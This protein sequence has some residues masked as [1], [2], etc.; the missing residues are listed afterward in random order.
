M[1][2]TIFALIL[3]LGIAGVSHADDTWRSSHTVTADTLKSLCGTNNRN[4]GRIHAVRV[5]HGTSG[6]ITLYNSQAVASNVFQ[7]IYAT[8]VVNAGNVMEY[9][10]NLSS[11][12]TY[13][14]SVAGPSVNILY[15][16]Y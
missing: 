16:C 1:K 6:V 2:K 4:R 15:N 14:T 8:S 7:V 13:T 9:D 12:L 3:L 10:V 5:G 11:G